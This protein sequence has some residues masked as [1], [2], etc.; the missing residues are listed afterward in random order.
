MATLLRARMCELVGDAGTRPL[1]TGT[2]FMLGL[3]SALESYMGMPAELITQNLDLAP[4][5]DAA[6]TSRRGPFGACLALVEAYE[7]GRW[8]ETDERAEEIGVEPDALPDLYLQALSWAEERARGTVGG[9][10]DEDAGERGAQVHA[11]G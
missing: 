6:L 3:L 8:N 4:E 11:L 2:L 7:N 10:A 9:G 5:L 1:A